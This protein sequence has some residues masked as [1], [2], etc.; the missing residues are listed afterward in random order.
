MKWFSFGSKKNSGSSTT[1]GANAKGKN[2]G[3][4]QVVTKTTTS[5]SALPASF[6]DPN[7]G[8]NP[9]PTLTRI[10]TME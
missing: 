10:D 1:S 9:K 5:D 6:S 8:S 4:D 7:Y 2:D 3:G